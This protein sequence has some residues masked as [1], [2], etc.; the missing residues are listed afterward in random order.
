[1]ANEQ[2]GARFFDEN[3][4]ERGWATKVVKRERPLGRLVVLEVTSTDAS[5]LAFLG[6]LDKSPLQVEQ[7]GDESETYNFVWASGY[8]NGATVRIQGVLHDT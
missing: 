7:T 5:L 4:R 3:K 2:V 1:M 6:S 8:E